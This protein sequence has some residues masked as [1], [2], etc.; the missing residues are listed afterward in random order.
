MFASLGPVLESSFAQAVLFN[1]LTYAYFFGFVFVAAWLLSSRRNATL[2]P[3]LG[4][5]AYALTSPLTIGSVVVVAAS[6]AHTLA[7]YRFTPS[8]GPTVRVAL[9]SSVGN[10]MGAAWLTHRL[11]STDP[12][13]AALGGL[14]IALPSAP[15]Y[16]LPFTVAA[17][18]VALAVATILLTAVRV[19]LLFILGASYVFYAH[20]DYRFLPLIFGSS[21]IDWLLG[22]AIAREADPRRRRRWLWATVALNLGVLGIFK[23][24]DFG[25]DAA[26][27]A[28][29]TLGFHPPPLA[30][31]LTL[32]IGISFFTFESMSYVIDVYRRHIPPHPSYV[33]YL[34]FVAFFPHLVAGP[35]VRPRDLL[36]Q[37]ADEPRFSSAE[38][39]EGIFLIAVGLVKKVAIGD[40]LALNLI[41]RVFDA[42]AHFSAL[43][44]YAALLGYSVQI[45]CDFSGYTDIAIG[46]ALLL[47]IRFPLNFDAP[48]TS[49]NIQ[50]FWRRWHIS[51]STWL[52]DYLY[53]PLGGNRRGSF[54]TYVN[55]M[56]TMLLAGLWHGAS[57]TFVLWG[58]L[59]GVALA[60]NRF[61][62]RLRGSPARPR[63]PASRA[64]ACIL[65]FHY[66]TFAWVLFRA[67]TFQAACDVYAQLGTGAT[68]TPNLHPPIL[69]V[70]ALGLGSHFI[71]DGLFRRIRDGFIALPAPAQA[72]GLFL[73]AL[74]LREIASADSLPFVY[75]QF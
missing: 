50:E 65:T 62:E 44:V 19:R 49:Q 15:I 5:F 34:S 58:G 66:V 8:T 61:T 13:S 52:R 27:V 33:Q 40:Y 23:Y 12:V 70:L 60:F 9:A 75:F 30:L 74:A 6:A 31:E 72:G 21:T 67:D 20:W 18:A 68:H 17:T 48:Y 46:S 63:L 2:L 51:L 24:F 39:S 1:T 43:E 45:Y 7:L 69:A 28:L 3:W 11:E 38:A 56:I 4:L 36:P 35:I 57:F 25:I 47:G 29:E 42:P 22:N 64:V 54:R 10:L 73:T 55:L 37:L 26:R 16:A 53:V 59:H 41:D 32:P 71:P 14:G